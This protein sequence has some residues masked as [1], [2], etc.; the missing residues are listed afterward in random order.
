VDIG[1][2]FIFPAHIVDSI[3]KDVEGASQECHVFQLGY[4]HVA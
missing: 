4:L 1:K 2:D 3:C